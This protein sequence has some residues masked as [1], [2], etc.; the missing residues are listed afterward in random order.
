MLELRLGK[1]P[2]LT[3]TAVH[4]RLGV[5]RSG[6]C[7]AELAG[8]QE[9]SDAHNRMSGL[10]G[11]FRLGEQQSQ[12]L[13]RSLQP[14]LGQLPPFGALP[15][16]CALK[17]E[18]ARISAQLEIVPAKEAALEEFPHVRPLYLHT[19]AAARTFAW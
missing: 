2:N 14:G 1:R 19:R 11:A 17:K 8:G 4:Q 5:G 6:Q 7:E 9:R 3:A 15:A 13:A 16:V 10:R 18:R 12:G